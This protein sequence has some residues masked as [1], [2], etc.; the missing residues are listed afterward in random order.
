MWHMTVG[1][2]YYSAF[3]PFSWIYISFILFGYILHN[4]DVLLTFSYLTFHFVNFELYVQK[5]EQTIL[6][7]S[8]PLSI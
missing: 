2:A 8:P 6:V 4:C 7:D 1:N 5:K 3:P